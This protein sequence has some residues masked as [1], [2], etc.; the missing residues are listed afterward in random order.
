MAI[1]LWARALSTP[2][3]SLVLVIATLGT[4][5]HAHEHDTSHIPEGQTVS[6]EPLV[7]L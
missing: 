5:T 6:V 3:L 4:V 1:G 7:C 2:S